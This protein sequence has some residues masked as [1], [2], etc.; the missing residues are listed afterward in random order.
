MQTTEHQTIDDLM[1]SAVS[2]ILERGEPVEARR[3]AN[4]EIRGAS[5][6]LTNPRARLSRTATRGKI[7]SALGE[8]LWYLSGSNAT[9]P[10]AYYIPQYRKDCEDGTVFGGYGPRLFGPPPKD[11]V[12]RI[13]SLLKENPHTRRAVISIFEPT[14]LI[15]NHKDI[16]CTCMLHFMV[17]SGKLHAIVY[18][19][20]NDAHYGLP[21]D[22]FCFSML[23]ELIAGHL[24]LDLGTYTHLAGS[25]HLY[26]KS[27]NNMKE[28][29]REGWQ[30]TTAPMPVMPH[31]DLEVSISRLLATEKNLRENGVWDEDS[32]ALL[33]PYWRDLATLLRGF[34]LKKDKRQAEIV[35]LVDQLHSP[36]YKIYLQEYTSSASN[37]VQT[38]AT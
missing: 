6:I 10:I 31:N 33:N 2:E 1:R 24:A 5:F 15:G 25:M 16:P 32:V 22:V 38:R 12:N 23:Q 14:D 36:V 35:S 19:R 21:H 29:L 9:N 26:D 4:K 37:F 34:R 30:E 17:R 18:M 28:F 13:I 20:S 3:G 8:L 11:Q 27:L 7:F